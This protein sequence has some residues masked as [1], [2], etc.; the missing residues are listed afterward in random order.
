MPG[1]V[2][3]LR[4]ELGPDMKVVF[5]ER[6]AQHGVWRGASTLAAAFKDKN[7]FS[8]DEYEVEGPAGIHKYAE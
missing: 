7:W 1:F 6:D 8:K 2:T 5:S 4:A 3:R